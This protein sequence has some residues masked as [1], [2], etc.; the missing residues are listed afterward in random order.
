MNT[1]SSREAL[2][3]KMQLT[4]MS[5]TLVGSKSTFLT[6]SNSQS[7]NLVRY[8]TKES[9]QCQHDLQVPE[10][11]MV[12][13]RQ[14]YWNGL[15]CPPPGDLPD[16]GIEPISLLS[17]ALAGGFCTT[18]APWEVPTTSCCCCCCCC[19]VA[20]VVS[21]S[22]RPHTRQPSGS[23]VF[24]ILQARTLEWVAISFSST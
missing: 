10:M 21:D 19:C 18:S 24:G 9:P 23:S 11:S 8:F 16:S 1:R 15:P 5:R 2:T 3:R 20:S 17:P 4:W 13:S 7:I 12:F 14:E 22:V 6:F